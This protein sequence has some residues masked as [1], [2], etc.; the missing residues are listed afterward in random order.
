MTATL[1]RLKAHFINWR[2][3]ELNPV[4]IK[5][6]RQSVRSW[7]VT[8]MLL[9]FLVVLFITSLVF[10]VNQTFEVTANERLGGDIFQAFI[11]ILAGASIMF[12]P[13][14][15]GVRMASERQEGNTDLLYISTLSPAR[16]IR[17]KFFCGAYMTLLFF[18]ACMPFMAFTNLLRGV[19]LP[20]V[21]FILLFL[22]VVV[23]AANQLAIFIACLPVSRP[24]KILFAI[25]GF[26][27]SYWLIAGV[28]F[29]A[30]SLMRS[31][32]GSMMGERYFWLTTLTIGGVISAV[33]GL[34][35]VLSV[36]LISPPSANRALL[37][38]IYITAFWLFGG[39]LVG[40]WAWQV[41]EPM[42][43]LVWTYASTVLLVA[44]LVV[45]V[46]N[47]DNLSVRVRRTIPAHRLKRALAFVYF[48]GAAGGLIW[49]TVLVVLTFLGTVQFHTV[50]TAYGGTRGYA[51]AD[52]LP[53]FLE[54]YPPVLVYIFAYAL[55][56]LFIQRKFM[57]RH[58]PKI[59]GIFTL[60][61]AGLAAIGP[62][63][64]LFF[65]NRLSWKTLEN[66]QLG[67]ASNLFVI[68]EPGPRMA[69]LVFA[70]G[71]LL[72]ALILNAKWFV[73]Q[74]KNFRP[75]PANLPPRLN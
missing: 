16:V 30:I 43:I 20:T 17:G 29:G 36:A 73:A 5:E 70:C 12:I 71:W 57:P 13:L 40:C 2:E 60:L 10:L 33:G 27:M 55:T 56:A 62:N 52:F 66:L 61:V 11:I 26:F 7:A 50:A 51:P 35:F 21:F 39:L 65:L 68:H 28:I 31:G 74:V 18:S 58:S 47:H 45:T 38:R 34:F 6:L 3:W 42:M 14:H 24:F 48:N 19:D 37:P 41:K 1:A 69:H 75:P 63:I 53:A 22:F 54:V 49:V 9:L 72:L 44:S 8:G 46:S 15:V 4:V 23:C 64:V 25:G 59:A 32:I 67:N